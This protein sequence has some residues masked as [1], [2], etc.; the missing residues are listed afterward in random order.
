V[1]VNASHD[2]TQVSKDVKVTVEPDRLSFWSDRNTED[3]Q[4][5]TM[6]S[7][8]TDQRVLFEEDAAFSPLRWSP[9]GRRVIFEIFTLSGG[10][11]VGDENLDYLSSLI[12][13]EEGT[14]LYYPVWSP[15]GR[16]IAAV[17]YD[18]D[19]LD[20]DLVMVDIDG[21]QFESLTNTSSIF[22]LLPDWSPDGST[23]VFDRTQPGQLGDIYT[24]NLA[25]RQQKR[26]T[27]NGADD[28]VPVYSPDGSKIM[29]LSTRDGNPEIYVMNSDGTDQV[30]ITTAPQIDVPGSWNADGTKIYF[31]SDRDGDFEIYVMDADGGNVT[32]L[33]NNSSFDDRVILVPRKSGVE[34][35][36]G[37]V[38]LASEEPGADSSVQAITA[39]ARRSVV[40]VLTNLASGSGWVIDSDGLIMTNNHVIVDAS[41]IAVRLDDGTNYQATVVG[42]DLTHD[43]AVLKIN[44]TGLIP[45]PFSAV[46]DEDLGGD[47]LV[48]GYPLGSNE[49]N[50]TRGVISAVKRDQG[51]NLNVVQTDA[52]VNFGNSGGPMLNLRGEVVGIVSAG[53]LNASVENV[54]F[55][56][57]SVSILNYLD[58]LLAGE[59]II[60]S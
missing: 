28:S 20:L 11:F 18:L 26:L 45:L 44:A 27:T 35:T 6:N 3:G 8:G 58:R 23:I 54:G 16:K 53:L 56:Y 55:A 9:D 50:V 42:R 21:G 10:I 1:K 38:V 19:T 46:T 47:V 57:G 34:V 52:A 4:F 15:D 41:S 25:T 43:L 22:E 59:T 14:A 7:D 40:K 49:L 51:R 13:N 12:T 17:Q 60:L 5:F 33:T 37:A 31:I 32:K 39:K 36:A 24:I 30:R 2:G 29:F 48:L